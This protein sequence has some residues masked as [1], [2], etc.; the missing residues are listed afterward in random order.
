[1]VDGPSGP[2]SLESEGKILPSSEYIRI[3]SNGT[4]S[5]VDDIIQADRIIRRAVEAAVDRR[6]AGLSS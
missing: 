4:D 2:C 3:F 1:M 5:A 6:P